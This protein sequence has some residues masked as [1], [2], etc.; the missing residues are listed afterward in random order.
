MLLTALL[1]LLVIQLNILAALFIFVK[2]KE[3]NAYMFQE[4]EEQHPATLQDI[5]SN[6]HGD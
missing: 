3:A 4:Q 5:L 2:R 1:I 6:L